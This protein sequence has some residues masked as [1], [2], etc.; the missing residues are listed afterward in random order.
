MS[1]QI[2][3]L[4]TA[5]IALAVSGCQ[6]TSSPINQGD[7]AVSQK[8]IQDIRVSN[9]LRD[10]YIS[11]ENIKFPGFM[12]Y[13]GDLSDHFLGANGFLIILPSRRDVL[14]VKTKYGYIS[15]EI[16]LEDLKSGCANVV[17]A[18]FR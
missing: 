4:Y 14:C 6:L 2:G 16:A 17:A 1:N 18:E 13:R 11:S 15:K 8:S 7:A 3:F 9:Y 5:I 12:G 10:N